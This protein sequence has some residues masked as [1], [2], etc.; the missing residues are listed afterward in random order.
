MQ[1]PGGPPVSQGWKR[2]ARARLVG[3]ANAAAT[4]AGGEWRIGAA[5]VTAG[6]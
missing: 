4:A 1:S 5:L 6:Y 3:N 2:M